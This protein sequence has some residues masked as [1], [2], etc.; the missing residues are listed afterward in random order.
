MLIINHHVTSTSLLITF[1]LLYDEFIHFS[2]VLKKNM[3]MTTK[4]ATFYSHGQGHIDTHWGVGSGERLGAGCLQTH[5]GHVLDQSDIHITS[6]IL[7]DLCEE[8]SKP[9]KIILFSRH[10]KEIMAAHFGTHCLNK[11][12]ISI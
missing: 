12:V 4:R 10:T 9:S 5:T 6:I 11:K 3:N 8:F 7:A 1:T 2:Q